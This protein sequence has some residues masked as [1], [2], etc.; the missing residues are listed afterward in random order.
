LY[1][2]N[3]VFQP[4]ILQ[5]FATAKLRRGLLGGGHG[6]LP[7]LYPPLHRLYCTMMDRTFAAKIKFKV[8]FLG[9]F[10]LLKDAWSL[11][12]ALATVM[13]LKSGLRGCDRSAIAGAVRASAGARWSRSTFPRSVPRLQLNADEC[14]DVTLLAAYL[15]SS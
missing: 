5:T 12:A 11:N 4:W 14:Y 7:P 9:I 13:K 10:L 1:F 2:Y 8:T 6:P 3:R 15:I